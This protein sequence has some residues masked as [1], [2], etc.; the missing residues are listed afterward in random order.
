M[1]IAANCK[2]KNAIAMSKMSFFYKAH[3]IIRYFDL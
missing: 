3:I 1:V 2:R